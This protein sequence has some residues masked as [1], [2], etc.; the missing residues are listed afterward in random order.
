MATMA[1]ESGPNLI[2]IQW[3]WKKK[4]PKTYTHSHT[5]TLKWTE[6]LFYLSTTGRHTNT[7]TL[8]KFYLF[9]VLN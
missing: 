8:I 5:H 7:D 3:S 9:I 4:K 1:A 6:T 2:M